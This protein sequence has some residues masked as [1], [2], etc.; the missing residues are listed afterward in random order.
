[1][2]SVTEATLRGARVLL[3]ADFN[4]PVRE[5]RVADDFRI[6]KTLPTIQYLREQGSRIVIIA[7]LG[8]SKESLAPVADA[9]KRA[10]GADVRFS[11]AA[12]GNELLA[13]TEDLG[14]GDVL[15]L[16]NIRRYEGEEAGDSAF[17][18]L[19]AQAGD[20]YVNDAFAVS[21]RAHASITE[22]PK[23]LPSYA[24]LLLR[25]EVEHLTEAL[26]PAHPCLAILG[27]AKFDTKR[28]LIEKFAG[29]Y[30]TVAVGGAL[31]NDF[32]KARGMEIGKSHAS[33]VSVEQALLSNPRL[34]HVHDFLLATGE[35]RGETEVGADESIVDIGPQSAER[36]AHEIEKAAFVL[37]N[38]NMGIYEQGCTAAD[39]MLAKA[40]TQSSAKA[41]I[42]GGDTLASLAHEEF[43]ENRVFLSTGGGAMLQFLLNGTLPG[44]E[45]L[46]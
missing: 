44:I 40:L 14:Q 4:V 12:P 30:D 45:A 35:V 7:H 18:Q 1:M 27:G 34:L 39:T 13:A 32:A 42:G 26:T 5:G 41:V 17:A 23:L 25:S 37:W 3:R 22:L 11:T 43:D 10:L 33:G 19:L 20:I 36:F 2:K 24:G 6:R 28:P 21:H 29:L 9:L 8:R 16:E 15:L 46:G 31:A 38:G